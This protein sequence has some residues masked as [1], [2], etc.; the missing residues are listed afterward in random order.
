MKTDNSATASRLCLTF[1]GTG[2]AGGLPLYG[3]KCRACVRAKRDPDYIRRP[4]SA[5]VE[6][7]GVRLLID[8][9]L[10]D[11]AERFPAGSLS[12]ILLTH[13]HPDHAQGLL[14]M[15]WGSGLPIVVWGPPDTQGFADLYKH[16]GILHFKTLV[17][18]EPLRVGDITITP[19]PLIHSKPTFGYHIESLG[20]KVAY[21]T[22]TVGLPLK[23]L[24][25]LIKTSPDRIILDCTYPPRDIMPRNHNDVTM[26][27]EIIASIGTREVILTHIGHEMDEWL[28]KEGN[29]LPKSVLVARDGKII[30][31]P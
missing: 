10:P 24:N 5:L 23:T 20:V 15:R 22:D 1:H 18:F 19:L 7:A 25:F 14:P 6:S 11:L 21:L 28:L 27:M 26:A 17:P 16:Q 29:N 9:G 2:D 31:L 13:Y 12:G 8:A 3:C 30:N 4:C